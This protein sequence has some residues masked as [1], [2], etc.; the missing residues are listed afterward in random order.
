MRVITMNTLN[1]Q[2]QLPKHIFLAETM[3][4]SKN[5]LL[6]FVKKDRCYYLR[7]NES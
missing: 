4:S 2:L 3:F 5:H 1:Q 7:S 6:L